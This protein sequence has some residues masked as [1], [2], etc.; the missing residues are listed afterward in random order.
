MPRVS[1]RAESDV[2]NQQRIGFLNLLV[3]SFLEHQH[4]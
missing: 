4:P 2:L 1:V 3:G